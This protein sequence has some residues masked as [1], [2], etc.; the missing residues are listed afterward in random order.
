[1]RSCENVSE[2]VKT[3]QVLEYC[4]RL[5]GTVIEVLKRRFELEKATE[6]GSV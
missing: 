6:D 4:Y 3:P 2:A 5:S 1:M